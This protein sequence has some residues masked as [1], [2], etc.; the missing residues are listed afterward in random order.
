M[1]VLAALE[2]VPDSPGRRHISTTMDQPG[3]SGVA[4]WAALVVPALLGA[5]AIIW[6]TPWGAGTSQDSAYYVCGARSFV[7]SGKIMACGDGRD[8]SPMTRF[9]PLYPLLLA[10]PS[11]IG[12]DPVPAA[13]WIGAV[14]L[15]VNVVLMGL[16]LRAAGASLFVSLLGELIFL[17]SDY[18][19][20]V[21]LIAWSDGSFIVFLLL[22]V[23][24]Y[25]R[26]LQDH[27]R[28]WIFLT[29]GAVV[30]ACMTRYIGV[31]LPL[32][33]AVSL[34]RFDLKLARSALRRPAWP[35]LVAGAALAAWL[36]RN[37]LLGS[38]VGRHLSGRPLSR[39]DLM[40]GITT[41][42]RWI[43]PWTGNR[44]LER[45][46]VPLFLIELLALAILI[47][48]N[49]NQLTLLLATMILGFVTFIMASHLVADSYVRLDG[50]L[51]LPILVSAIIL[52]MCGIQVLAETDGISVAWRRAGVALAALVLIGHV[53]DIAP[54][55]LR[56][57]IAGFGYSTPRWVNSP[58]IGWLRA[59][60]PDA[61]IY[62]DDP[63]PIYLL[64]GRLT[65]LLPMLRDPDSHQPYVR[66]ASE[67]AEMHRRL[68]PGGGIIAF[69]FDDGM[70]KRRVS[71]PQPEAMAAQYHLTMRPVYQADEAIIY[72]VPPA[73]PPVPVESRTNGG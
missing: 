33:A 55:L 9:P 11:L 32:A 5:A 72:Q 54:F 65:K 61:V 20:T 57:R 51:T 40:L 69:F 42:A 2:Q 16:V 62:T 34:T 59:L 73:T 4:R 7:Q 52:V 60:P 19:L 36:V 17:T 3:S 18:V 35:L 27:G 70:P 49:P 41:A 25:C 38:A 31:V 39:E 50:R 37:H 28:R 53:C 63:E 26:W 47:Y 44:T 64:T 66:F 23:Y 29:A 15:A 6:A 67:L 14:T 68:S 21:H 46:V 30:A 48:R 24:G 1:P 56:K 8:P 45:L 13:R 22:F 10:A 71:M 12:V 58:A 43:V